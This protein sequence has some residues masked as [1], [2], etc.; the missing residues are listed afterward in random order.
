M[1]TNVA[2]IKYFSQLKNFYK[3]REPTAVAAEENHER[4]SKWAATF[5][6][7]SGRDQTTLQT[8]PWLRIIYF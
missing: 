2:E 7:V 5:E 8:S 1:A 3:G 6:A 4:Y